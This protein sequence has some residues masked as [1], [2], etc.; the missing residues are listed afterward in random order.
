MSLLTKT[1][2]AAA[3]A[4][5]LPAMAQAVTVTTDISADQPYTFSYDLFPNTTNEFIFNVTEDLDIDGFALSGTGT[6][7]GV[8]L[9]DVRFGFALPADGKFTVITAGTIAAGFGFLEGGSFMAGDTFMIYFTDGVKNK[10][11]TTL[12]F[13]TTSPAAVPLP[14]AGGLLVLA[15]GAVAAARRKKS[16]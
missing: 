5:A 4:I 16:A 10:V 9:S 15:I 6:N 13:D 11:G 1:F 3:V 8:D 7:S 14:A 12:S 2:T